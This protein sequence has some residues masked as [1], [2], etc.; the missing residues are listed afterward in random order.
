MNKPDLHILMLEDDP[1]DAELNKEQLILLE[2]YQC[3]FKIVDNKADYLDALKTYSPDII[4]CDYNLPLYNGLEALN[5]LKNFNALIPFIFVT[6][7]MKEETA[8][9]A[10]KAGAWDYVVKDRLFRLPLAVRS[11][12][13]LKSEKEIA[14]QTQE[15]ID[16]LLMAVEQTSTQIIVLNRDHH[17]EYVNK[18]F[19]E[20][21][22]FKPKDVI[23]KSAQLLS[24]KYEELE[25]ELNIEKILKE[26]KEYK[27]EA[28]SHKKDGSQYW[29]LISITPI[30]NG[31]NELTNFIIIKEDIT[32]RKEMEKELINAR[33]RAEQSDKLKDAFLQNMSHEIRTPLN[34]IT[35]FSEL[36]MEKDAV[37]YESIAHYASIINNSSIQLLSIVSDVLTMASIQTGEET[38]TQKPVDICQML[39]HLYEIFIPKAQEKKLYFKYGKRRA[40]NR[41]ITLTDETK[42]AQILTNLLNNA[43]KFTHQGWI[44][45]DYCL[46]N[47]NIEFYV[48]D[49]GTGI[50][51]EYHESIFERFLQVDP[52]LHLNYGGTG[53]GL[54]IS[55]SFAELLGGS[56]RVESEPG[57]GSLFCLSIPYNSSEEVKEVTE[58][59][60]I[61]ARSSLHVLIAEDE[62]NNYLLLKSILS[63]D[64]IT[65]YHAFN[66][67][68]AVEKCRN[69]AEINIV[70]MDIKMPVMD[71]ITALKE[72]H[73]FRKD[74]P[75]IAQTAYAL[76]KDKKELLQMGFADY[77]SKPIDANELLDKIMKVF[78]I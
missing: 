24:S 13:N 46:K 19:T 37:N 49:S 2:E 58:E 5:N 30:K 70:L 67:L 28:L 77:I 23:G 52:S 43:C 56:I 15:R 32:A 69:N 64:N 14:M 48:K 57:E 71:G 21:T 75:M 17:I 61:L 26:G 60:S 3:N 59:H 10:I 78:L 38:I 55:K 74:L 9:D 54:S 20:V 51:K 63:R 62:Y 65:S 44:E 53:L 4:L 72:I 66:G 35:G 73:K 50:A 36:L 1:L 8:A 7:T 16:N 39:E 12:L 45:L 6:G 68:E 33:D 11:V 47:E 18:K 31:M 22:G 41:I 29:E 42:L 40:D 34:A 27:G 76:E 25:T